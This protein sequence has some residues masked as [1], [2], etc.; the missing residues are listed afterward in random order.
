MYGILFTVFLTT[1]L[2]LFFFYSRKKIIAE[3]LTKIAM[4]LDNQKNMVKAIIYTQEAERKRIAQD[5]HDAISSKLNVVSLS[6]NLLIEDST[7]TDEQHELL[8]H[9]LGIMNNTLESARRI[10][11]DLL[12]PVFDEFGLK[13]ALDEL[14]D[15]YLKTNQVQILHTIEALPSVPKNNGLHIFRIVQELIN[16]AM[17]HGNASQVT[18]ILKHLAPGFELTFNDNGSGFKVNAIAEKSGI[19][20]QNIESRVAILKAS[21]EIKSEKGQGS[22]FYIKSL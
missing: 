2:M 14:L 8:K 15:D 12:P 4:E 1:G 9:M 11:H 7:L 3:Q 13:V 20:L 5:M 19:G 21:L 18:I 17:R 16:N 10:A 6:T 22:T